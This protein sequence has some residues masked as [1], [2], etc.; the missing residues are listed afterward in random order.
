MAYRNFL[1]AAAFGCFMTALFASAGHAEAQAFPSRPV[2]LIVPF[3]PGATTDILARAVAQEPSVAW[4]QPVIV[5][6]RPGASGNIGATQVANAAPDGHTLLAAAAPASRSCLP[7]SKYQRRYCVPRR[8]RDRA[9][10]ASAWQQ[11][12]M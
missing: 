9:T 8:S 1:R 3:A 5:E 6:N 12:R 11:W 7:P 4:H 10:A 2:T